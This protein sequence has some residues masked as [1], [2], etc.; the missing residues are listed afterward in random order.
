M[1][2]EEKKK[3]DVELKEGAYRRDELPPLGV[4]LWRAAKEGL[5]FG[6]RDEIKRH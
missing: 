2:E 3:Q 1:N 5:E 4:C 6:E